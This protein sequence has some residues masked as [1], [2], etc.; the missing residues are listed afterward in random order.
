MFYKDVYSFIQA[1]TAKNLQKMMQLAQHQIQP[2]IHRLKKLN[3]TVIARLL[4]ITLIIQGSGR[5]C[6]PVKPRRSS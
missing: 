6:Q 2:F 1:E 4:L 3:V 5:S